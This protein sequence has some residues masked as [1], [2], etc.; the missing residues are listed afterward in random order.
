[1]GALSNSMCKTQ[2]KYLFEALWAP[3]VSF[4]SIYGSSELL[5]YKIHASSELFFSASSELFFSESSELFFSE[6]S[7][8][9]F[10]ASSELFLLCVK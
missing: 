2:D 9:F 1:M 7:E 8:L 10:S 4:S 6:S 3:K 5:F